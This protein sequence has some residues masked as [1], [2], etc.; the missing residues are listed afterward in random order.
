MLSNKGATDESERQRDHPAAEMMHAK[1]E[2]QHRWLENLLVIGV[3]TEAA[4]RVNRRR[5]PPA[6][7]PFARL[8]AVDTGQEPPRDA[9]RRLAT[10]V[11][12]FAYDTAAKRF[13]GSS[14]GSMMNRQWAFHGELDRA[15]R[16]T[17]DSEVPSFSGDG[18]CRST[19]TSS[20]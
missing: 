3:Q 10:S 15:A 6:P 18:S 4:A 11:M 9:R 20:S 19:R 8:V 7:K 14:I 17:L 5:R 13:V 12:T 2:Q 1:P 16:V